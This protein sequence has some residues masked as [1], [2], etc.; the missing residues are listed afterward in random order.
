MGCYSVY[1]GISNIGITSEK[2]E[3]YILPIISRTKMCLSCVGFQHYLPAMLPILATYNGY[4]NVQ[5]IVKDDNT[6]LIENYFNITIEEFV[7]YL[8]DNNSWGKGD[9]INNEKL[10]E[11]KEYDYMWVLK[12]V[13][14]ELTTNY[15]YKYAKYDITEHYNISNWKNKPENEKLNE[16]YN[17]FGNNR[18]TSLLLEMKK[19]ISP[20][21][22]IS[23][24]Y[25][26]LVEIKLLNK[27][28]I[29]NEYLKPENF[30]IFADRLVSLHNVQLNISYI[31]KQFTPF[32]NY[33]TP[34]GADKKYEEKIFRIFI[35]ATKTKQPF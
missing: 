23:E 28:R 7:K 2:E 32:I 15:Q 3:V 4:G 29:C 8:I 13:Y 14:D 11:L 18:T 35:N 25:N 26:K 21:K 24:I 17:L 19:S 30:E 22:D 1:C 20:E 6:Q 31:S 27:Y 12:S 16:F 5:N 9:I 34:Q 33:I 10:D